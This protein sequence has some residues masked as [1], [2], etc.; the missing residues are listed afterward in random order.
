MRLWCL[1][2]TEEES[3]DRSRICYRRIPDDYMAK[4]CGNG[5]MT[6]DEAGRYCWASYD[7]DTR[8]HD[9][10]GTKKLEDLGHPV[11]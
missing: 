6:A 11:K 4:L 9:N 3:H 10:H 7:S 1:A 8:Q 5:K 2:L